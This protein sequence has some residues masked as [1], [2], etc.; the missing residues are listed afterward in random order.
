MIRAV[1]SA[2]S[3]GSNP[4]ETA[5]RAMALNIALLHAMENGTFHEISG[6][7]GRVHAMSEVYYK[8]LRGEIGEEELSAMLGSVKLSEIANTTPPPPAGGA[9]KNNEDSE[10]KERGRN[11]VSEDG[12]FARVLAS[13]MLTPTGN[14]KTEYF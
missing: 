3:D 7:A 14:K 6:K 12:V 4:E 11:Q 1:A 8:F 13:L 2:V 9:S 10:D 5:T